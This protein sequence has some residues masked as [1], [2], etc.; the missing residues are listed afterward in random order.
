MTETERVE[1]NE[2]LARA[3]FREAKVLTC[4]RA[5]VNVMLFSPPDSGQTNWK[6]FDFTRDL[7]ASRELVLW[8]A[9]SNQDTL[10]SEDGNPLPWRIFLDALWDHCDVILRAHETQPEAFLRW[11][12]TADPLLIA[13]AADAAIGGQR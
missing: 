7:A 6:Y 8:L 1:L 11:V 3:M 9:G 12:L 5:G 4:G 10:I 2:R 13:L